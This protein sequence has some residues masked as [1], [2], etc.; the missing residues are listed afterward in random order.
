MAA[1]KRRGFLYETLAVGAMRPS[2]TRGRTSSALGVPAWSG[3]VRVTEDEW[4]KK[5]RATASRS[6][7]DR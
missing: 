7:L 6:I 1:V 3:A 5:K 2:P 4:N